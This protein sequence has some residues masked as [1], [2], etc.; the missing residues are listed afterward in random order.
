MRDAD[1]QYPQKQKGVSQGRDV[2]GVYDIFVL[3]M[4]SFGMLAMLIPAV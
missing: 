4:R 1:K 2:G 3:C